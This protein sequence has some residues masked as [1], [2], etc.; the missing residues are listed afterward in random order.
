MGSQ[1]TP[2]EVD[3]A[4]RM[5]QI[6][7]SAKQNYARAFLEQTGL[8]PDQVVMCYGERMVEGKRLFQV[9]FVPKEENLELQA[10]REFFKTLDKGYW[11][12]LHGL[13][14]KMAALCERYP[15][16]RPDDSRLPL[17]DPT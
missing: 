3:V 8:T 9:W 16:L 5:S 2:Q 12:D 17:E 6:V 1:F 15:H 14:N 13:R 7:E 11:H 10:L 4:L